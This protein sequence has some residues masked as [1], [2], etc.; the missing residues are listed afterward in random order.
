MRRLRVTM[1]F[2]TS[3]FLGLMGTIEVKLAVMITK[4]KQDF[5]HT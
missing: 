1:V 2:T 4:K 3:N 5:V